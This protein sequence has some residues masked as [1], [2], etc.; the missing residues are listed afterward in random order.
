MKPRTTLIV[1]AVFLA[2]LAY[3][4]FGELN[5]PTPAP[6]TPTPTRVW[7]LAADQVVGLT[8]RSGEKQTR[9][10][11]STEGEWRLEARTPEPADEERIDRVLGNLAAM[12]PTRTFTEVAGL[13][14]EYGLMQPSLEA[15]VQLADGSTQTLRVGA[16]NPQQT[17]YYA[18]VEGAA[19]VH[20][21]PA[22]LI[23]SLRDLL[24]QP[25]IR[26]TPTPTLTA[27]PTPEATATPAAT[28]SG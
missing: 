1:V 6:T 10:V 7:S 17:A 2:L 27:T 22:W 15:T 13:L 14:E 16:P 21:L 26:P 28:P 25:P 8:I 23:T 5:R 19:D 24:D 18:Q 11:R 3:V 20:L 9:L 12:N 4:Y